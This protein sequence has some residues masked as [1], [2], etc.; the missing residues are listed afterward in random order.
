MRERQARKAALAAAQERGRLALQREIEAARRVEPDP[1]RE[2]WLSAKERAHE[3]RMRVRRIRECSPSPA[4]RPTPDR[5]LRGSS[6]SWS[7]LRTPCL[8]DGRGPTP[9]RELPASESRWLTP[10]SGSPEGEHESRL[11]RPSFADERRKPE[12]GAAVARARRRAVD[13]EKQLREEK[14]RLAHAKDAVRD[15]L[16]RK[17]DERLQK[18]LDTQTRLVSDVVS[19]SPER[20]RAAPE[21]LRFAEQSPGGHSPPRALSPRASPAAWLGDLS[22]F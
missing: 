19:V 1:K 16:F 21:P 20:A 9:D 12:V 11:P 22:A 18:F 3:D 10:S 4:L 14:Y 5:D 7:S 15:D 2:R 8:S 13:A 17:R 6:E